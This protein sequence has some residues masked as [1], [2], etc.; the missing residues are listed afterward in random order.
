M[1][2]VPVVG[3]PTIDPSPERLKF[4]TRAERNTG[5]PVGGLGRVPFAAPRL[6]AQFQAELCG[7]VR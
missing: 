2:V 3:V 1:F 7:D 6:T 5:E 4:G